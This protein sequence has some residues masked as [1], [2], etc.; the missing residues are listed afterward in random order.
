M[1]REIKG[2]LCH[3][4]LIKKIKPKLAFSPEV[5]FEEWKDNCKNKL[6]ELLGID[7]IRKNSCPLNLLVEEEERTEEYLKIRFSFESEVGAFVPCY[8]LVPKGG[9]KSYPLAICLQGHTGGFHHSIGELKKESDKIFQPHTAHA[10][11]AVKRGYAA[12]A[13]EQR[14][15]GE[16]QSPLYPDPTVHACAINALTAI[17]LGRT[18]IG[19]RVWDVSRAIDCMSYFCDCG[20]DLERIMI[21]GHSG[22]GTAAYYS[23]CFDERIGYS[24]TCGAFCSFEK[25]IMKIHHCACNYIP[26]ICNYFEMADLSCLIAPRRLSVMTGIYDD[27]FP[28]DGVEEA[29]SAIENI[30]EKASCKDKIRLVTS[31]SGHIFDEEIFWSAIEEETHK[32]GWN[33]LK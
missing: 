18:T 32:M 21:L 12:L 33:S 27:I 28:I 2:D 16:R 17:N 4:L 30:F 3:D 23:T 6:Y 9:K 8:L 25:S 22:G 7:N 5:D 24:A 10:L 26:N 20:I 14:A 19:E 13:I 11:Q 31:P 15:M 1:R 29:F